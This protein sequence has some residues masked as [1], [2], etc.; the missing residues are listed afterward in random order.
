MAVN[1]TPRELDILAL[2]VRGKKNKEIAT[3]MK[4]SEHMVKKYLVALYDKTG[5][6][7]RVELAMWE[8]KRRADGLHL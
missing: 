2:L 8:L 1:L 7:S 6:G 4:K 5:M 3:A